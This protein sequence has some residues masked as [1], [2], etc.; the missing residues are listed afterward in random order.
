MIISRIIPQL[1][2]ENSDM[3]HGATIAANGSLNTPYSY[4]ADYVA[5]G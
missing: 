3:I 4:L 5:A 1:Q 2:Q